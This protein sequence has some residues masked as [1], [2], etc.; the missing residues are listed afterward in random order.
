MAGAA[1]EA[2]P[3]LTRVAV[4]RDANVASGIGQFAAIQTVAPIGTELSV[5]GVRNAGEVE[6]AI[7]ALG[8]DFRRHGRLLG[9]IETLTR[10]MSEDRIAAAQSAGAAGRRFEF[11]RRTGIR[12]VTSFAPEPTPFPPQPPNIPFD[13]APTARA[14]RVGNCRFVSPAVTERREL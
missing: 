7:A 14:S 12:D 13:K 9:D 2:A 3:S 8:R 4:L 5:I 1:K 11:R 6:N 10:A